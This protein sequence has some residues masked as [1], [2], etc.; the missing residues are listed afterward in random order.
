M[1]FVVLLVDRH[2]LFP[3]IS[4]MFSNDRHGASPLLG[5][6]G[7]NKAIGLVTSK[8]ILTYFNVSRIALTLNFLKKVMG[9]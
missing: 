4:K 5:R 7:D 9:I 2:F 3:P 8:T 6:H 1:K